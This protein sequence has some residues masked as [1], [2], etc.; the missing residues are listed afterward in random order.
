MSKTLRIAALC[1][2][3]FAAMVARAADTPTLWNSKEIKWSDDAAPAGAKHAAL[4]GGS[5]AGDSGVLVR[6]KFNTKVPDQVRMQDLHIVVLAGTLTLE[7]DG[8]Y[9]EF[10]PGGFASIPKGVKHTMGCEA[11]GECTFLMHQPV[12]PDVVGA[13]AVP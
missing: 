13:K 12:S 2:T 11:A 10:G 3:L 6:W 9:K 8:H 5:A 1:L 4:W 7:I